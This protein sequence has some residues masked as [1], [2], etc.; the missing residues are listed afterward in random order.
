MTNRLSIDGGPE[1]GEATPFAAPDA[2]GN[3][4]SFRR[5]ADMLQT[6]TRIGSDMWS[7]PNIKRFPKPAC[8]NRRRYSWNSALGTIQLISAKSTYT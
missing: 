2:G 3:D 7:E 1:N 5:V 6:R 8:V 4:D